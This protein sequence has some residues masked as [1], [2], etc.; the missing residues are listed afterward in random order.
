MAGGVPEDVGNVLTCVIVDNGQ[1]CS[2]TVATV[3]VTPPLNLNSA[4]GLYIMGKRN[5]QFTH[6][7]SFFFTAGV[8]FIDGP[9][10]ADLPVG[11]TINTTACF[12]ITIIDDMVVDQTAIDSE[13]IDLKLDDA[14]NPLITAAMFTNLESIAINDNDG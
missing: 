1:L 13:V 7:L 11:S 12:N 14:S 10:T 6:F 4:T 2:S 5:L 3:T 8:D 9:F